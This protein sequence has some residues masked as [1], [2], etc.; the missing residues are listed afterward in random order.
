MQG[1]HFCDAE[2]EAEFNV[3]DEIPE[4][5][6]VDVAVD[7]GAGDNVLA[8]VDVPGHKVQESPGSI[9]GQQFKG[10]GGHV[11]ANEG[12]MVLEMLAPLEDGQHG[13]VDVCWQVAEVR[14]PLLSVSKICDKAQHT[15]TFDAK[16]AVVRDAK[17]RIVC[18][19]M[20]KG[21]L[22]I[23]RMKVKNPNHPSFGGQGK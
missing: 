4:Y 1:M 13:E 15:V 11:M 18:I 22:Y 23:G 10:A 16:R 5:M 2:P 8:A 21:N 17:G 7:S 19:F 9:R 20:R 14:R 12:Q 6:D 3:S